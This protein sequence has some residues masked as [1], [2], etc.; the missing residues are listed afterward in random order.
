MRELGL[1][2]VVRGGRVRTTRPAEDPAV[3]P[4]DLVQ[5]QFTAARP[6]APGGRPHV[7]TVGELPLSL[8]GLRGEGAEA[9]DSGLGTWSTVEPVNG[10]ADVHADGDA[11][12]L[13]S[14][15]GQPDVA[16]TA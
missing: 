14:G 16:A 6:T 11:D 10:A 15:L 2:G 5:R 12:L 3:A 1:R 9:R 7:D 4:Q 13:Q 8:G